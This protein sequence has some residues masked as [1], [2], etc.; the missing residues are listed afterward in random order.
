[1][2][3]GVVCFTGNVDLQKNC[4]LTRKDCYVVYLY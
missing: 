3:H 4:S 1:M 2:A